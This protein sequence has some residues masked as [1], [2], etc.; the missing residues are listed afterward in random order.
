MIKSVKITD[1]MTYKYKISTETTWSK[2]LLEKLMM[3]QIFQEI[4]A[5]YGT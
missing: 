1:C 3:A 5:V 2:V 4:P